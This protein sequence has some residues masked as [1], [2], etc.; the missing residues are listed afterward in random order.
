MNRFAQPRMNLVKPCATAL[1]EVIDKVGVL[2]IF[3]APFAFTP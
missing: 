1:A 2:M 3:T